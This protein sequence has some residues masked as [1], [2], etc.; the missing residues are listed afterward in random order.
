MSQKKIRLLKL[1]LRMT[2]LLSLTVLV[3]SLTSDDAAFKRAVFW[4]GLTSPGQLSSVHA[5]L[6]KNCAACHTAVIGVEAKKCIL[7]HVSQEPLLSRQPTSFHKNVGSCQD[8]HM[9]HLGRNRRPTKM[10][11][12]MLAKLG[13]R[14]LKY[15]SN[16]KNQI[17]IWKL[18][19]VHQMG[20]V[21]KPHAR[22]TTTEML[23]N[24]VTCHSK[25]D[26]HAGYFGNNCSSCHGTKAWTIPEY[27]HPPE[28]ST[29]CAQCHKIPP[30]HLMP[31]FLKKCAKMLKKSPKSPKDC[32]VCH[33]ISSWNDM[34]GAPWHRKT[35]SH[36][37]VRQ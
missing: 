35:M 20:N 7:C 15:Q 18:S 24:C 25:K 21:Q 32:Y 14:Q 10:D 13:L 23:L 9:E 29:N 4:Q 33:S 27:I 26:P 19:M 1:F 16:K 37:P 6:Q 36:A 30:S 5:S 31:M 3:W 17:R 12:T 2:F 8:C 28:E 34:K 11:H 22:I